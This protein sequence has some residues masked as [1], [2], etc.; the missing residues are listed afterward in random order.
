MIRLTEIAEAGVFN[1]PHGIAG[2]ISATLDIDV[3]L[4]EVKCI[5][6][7]IDGIYV[8]FFVTAVR[9]KS[10][11]TF[12][13]TIKGIDTEVK[14]KSLT[15]KKFYILRADLPENDDDDEDGLYA[16]DLIGYKV[17]DKAQGLLGQITGV[18]DTTANVL[19]EIET[20]GGK[21]LLVPVADEFIL[22]IDSD[23]EI[24]ETDIPEGLLE[25]N[26]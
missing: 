18:N 8:P 14:A 12:L 11:D 23:N 3:D 7:S 15:N 2:E 4:R 21:T 6:V 1:K 17:E 10:A 25:L 5:V 13:L 9:P 22:S 16:S 20:T 26:S 19:F 24:V